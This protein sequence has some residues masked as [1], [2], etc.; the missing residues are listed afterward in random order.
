MSDDVCTGRGSTATNSLPHEPAPGMIL[1]EIPEKSGGLHQ[2]RAARLSH[3]QSDGLDASR[4]WPAMGRLR[5]DLPMS[6]WQSRRDGEERR[7]RPSGL[8]RVAKLGKGANRGGR[9]GSRRLWTRDNFRVP[10][11]PSAVKLTIDRKEKRRGGLGNLGPSDSR[12]IGLCCRRGVA[13]RGGLGQVPVPGGYQFPLNNDAVSRRT[14]DCD[15]WLVLACF[16]VF[17]DIFR[18][19]AIR[20]PGRASRRMPPRHR[21]G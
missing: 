5:V 17:F 18:R 16:G 11:G 21:P 20:S 15:K 4:Q 9:G 14:Q 7:V 13:R 1:V 8:G 2:I 19:Q 3:L 12:Q 10:P 6:G